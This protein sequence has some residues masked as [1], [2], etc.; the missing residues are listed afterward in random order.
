MSG[1]LQERVTDALARVRNNRLGANVVEAEMVRDIATTVDGKVRLTLFLSA[2]DDATVVR[3][4]RQTL[5]QVPG[6]TDVRVDVKDV[7]QSTRSSTPDAARRQESA[8]GGPKT[9]ALPVMGQ[10]PQSR[11]ASVP[12]PTPVAYPNLGNIIAVSS[13]KGG[14]G[15]STV[16]ANLAVAMAKQGARVGLMDADIYGPNIPRMMGISGQP[17][18]ENEKIIP[19]RAHGVKIMS[20]GFMID[21][22]QPAIWRGPIIM[23]IITQFLRDVQWGELDYFFVD[24]PPGTGDAQLSLV[25]ATMVHGAVIVTTPQE[26]AAGDALRGAKMFQRVAVPVLGVVENMSYFVCP[27]CSEKHRI[28]G[29]GG[30]DRLARELDVPLLAE[31]PFFPAL[32]EGADRGEPIVL[33]APDSPAAEA[34]FELAGR[35]S[36][37]LAGSNPAGV[38]AATL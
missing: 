1:N 29:E 36:G 17:P 8:P 2:D 23:K 9:R 38:N 13:G 10:E 14:V 7:A 18:V 4:V 6:V 31:I 5:Q 22:D 32:L 20:L 12:A 21:R 30:G 25:Q 3:E 16:A 35:L 19:L 28:F 37:L 34:L 26:V 15:K 24:M 33:S 27:S 11:R